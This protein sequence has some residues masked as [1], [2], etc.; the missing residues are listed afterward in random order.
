MCTININLGENRKESIRFYSKW[1][2]LYRAREIGECADVLD[3]D[4]IDC[5]TGEVY[6]TMVN[7]H[8]TYYEGMY[9]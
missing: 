8:V 1:A 6:M 7:Q 4:V 5:E 3:L 2:C 9:L